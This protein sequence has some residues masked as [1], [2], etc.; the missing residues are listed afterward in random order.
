MNSIVQPAQLVADSPSP[1][2][3]TAG[4]QPVP[5]S[6]A[7]EGRNSSPV[8]P[9]S[10]WMQQHWSAGIVGGLVLIEAFA[11]FVCLIDLAHFLLTGLS[12]VD[13]WTLLAEKAP[14]EKWTAVI[15]AAFVF[16]L[17]F[18]LFPIA[19]AALIST[20]RN[21]AEKAGNRRKQQP[22]SGSVSPA[23][24]IQP[25]VR[26]VLS[27]WL[28]RAL[29]RR[30]QKVWILHLLLSLT[31]SF[32]TI[33]MESMQVLAGNSYTIGSSLHPSFFSLWLSVVF[34][35]KIITPAFFLPVAR[36]YLVRL[37]GGEHPHVFEVLSEIFTEDGLKG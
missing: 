19:N 14:F 11:L 21:L 23:V 18:L 33:L 15:E 2:S 34:A 24:P 3:L 25:F 32:F 17:F 29:M 13:A 26:S 7:Y 28:L 4:P 37:F 9:P 16:C 22:T 8:A 30:G 12:V 20:F 10:T 5:G 31:V 36:K 1:P 27:R 35:V 6:Q